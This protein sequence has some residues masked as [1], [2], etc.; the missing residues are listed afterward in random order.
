M[1]E[2]FSSV[3]LT[4]QGEVVFLLF[5]LCLLCLLFLLGEVVFLLLLFLLGEVAFLLEFL[6]SRHLLLVFLLFSTDRGVLVA[7]LN[8]FEIWEISILGAGQDGAKKKNLK[9]A[10][11]TSE[12]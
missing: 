7:T 2:F 6:W 10:L 9:Y 8:K 5:L 4:R 12:R 11:R 3:D 1:I